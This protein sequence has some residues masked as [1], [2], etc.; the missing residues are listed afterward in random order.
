MRDVLSSDMSL[1]HGYMYV[2]RVRSGR[3]TL[4]A[5][6]QQQQPAMCRGQRAEGRWM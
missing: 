1:L 2:P 6:Q 4:G 3:I 5:G